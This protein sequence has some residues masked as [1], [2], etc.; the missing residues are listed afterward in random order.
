[1]WQYITL[2][3]RVFLIDCPGIVYSETHDSEVETV[4]KGVVRVEKL[5]DATVYIPEVLQRIKPE[6]LVC[7]QHVPAL[8]ALLDLLSSHT[9]LTRGALDQPKH[10]AT[11]RSPSFAAANSIL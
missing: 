1:V 6:Y 2:T 7:S 3:K 8:P 10:R 11:S 9:G 5:E 4:L